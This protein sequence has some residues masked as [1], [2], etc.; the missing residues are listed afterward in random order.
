MHILL[1][2]YVSVDEHCGYEFPWSPVRL[3]QHVGIRLGATAGG[4]DWHHS[5]NAGMYASQFAWWDALCGTDKV[6]KSW[7]AKQEALQAAPASASASPVPATSP[8]A[9]ARAGSTNVKGKQVEQEVKEAAA[10]GS[11]RREGARRRQTESKVQ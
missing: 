8:R 6:Y 1:R 4:H 2:I 11:P 5:H 10:A 9:T 3:L 7:L